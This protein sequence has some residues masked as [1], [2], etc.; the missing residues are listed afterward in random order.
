MESGRLISP[1]SGAVEAEGSAR[2][3]G[4]VLVESAIANHILPVCSCHTLYAEN[5]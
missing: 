1:L 4:F 5:K 3:I 2:T